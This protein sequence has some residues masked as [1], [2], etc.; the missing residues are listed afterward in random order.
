MEKQILVLMVLMVVSQLISIFSNSKFF[1]FF[2]ELKFYQR[3]LSEVNE[4]DSNQG[5]RL[6][7]FIFVSLTRIAIIYYAFDVMLNLVK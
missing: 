1:F 4:R 6:F 3:K 7:V 5:I 2:S